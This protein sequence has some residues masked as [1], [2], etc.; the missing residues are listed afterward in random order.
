MSRFS[1]ETVRRRVSTTNRL[2]RRGGLTAGVA[3]GHGLLRQRQLG[4]LAGG[5]HGE[6]LALFRLGLQTRPRPPGIEVALADEFGLLGQS[7][8]RAGELGQPSRD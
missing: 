8:L 2:R 6:A 1:S 5:G 7:R 3:L 4:R